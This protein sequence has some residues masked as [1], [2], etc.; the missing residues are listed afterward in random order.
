MKTS[1]RRLGRDFINFYYYGKLPV[2]INDTDMQQWLEEA[3]MARMTEEE[4]E[5][6]IE[7]QM[8]AVFSTNEFNSKIF[9]ALRWTAM[10]LAVHAIVRAVSNRKNRK[11]K[12]N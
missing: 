1:L 5:Y 3:E 8:D 2:E 7:K 6:Y 4:T 10:I 11:A 9:S 12:F